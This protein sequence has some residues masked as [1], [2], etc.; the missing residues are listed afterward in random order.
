VEEKQEQYQEKIKIYGPLWFKILENMFTQH[1]D[2]SLK[3]TSS[4]VTALENQLVRPYKYTKVL[5]LI[6][7]NQADNNL[8]LISS[9]LGLLMMIWRKPWSENYSVG[10]G[11]FKMLKSTDNVWLLKWIPIKV[12]PSWE[13]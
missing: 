5:C 10:K 12:W 13:M 6:N 11:E 2:S 9:T 4:V 3:N 1:L 7:E 8:A